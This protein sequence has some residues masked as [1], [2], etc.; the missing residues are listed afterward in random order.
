MPTE[1]TLRERFADVEPMPQ[2]EGPAPIVRIAYPDGF[3]TVMD[4]FR[5]IVV[6]G[7]PLGPTT[8][9]PR[10]G[11]AALPRARARRRDLTVTVPPR[12]AR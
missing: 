12:C 10:D 1:A 2:D 4:Y 3:S 9:P 7:A 6:N 11:C 5:R 8:H